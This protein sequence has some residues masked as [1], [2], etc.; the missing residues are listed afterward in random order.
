MQSE[1]S[2]LIEILGFSLLFLI[3]LIGLGR[4]SDKVRDFFWF[5]SGVN[6]PILK[7]CPNEYNRYSNIGATIFFT[8]LLAL[9]SMSYALNSVFQSLP[10]SICFGFIWS[11][12]IFT[13]DRTIVSS[14]Q[15]PAQ[16]TSY[17][18]FEFWRESIFAAIRIIVAIVI[19]LVIM[20]PL[21]I[22]IFEDRLA[23]EIKNMDD[24]QAKLDSVA[25]EGKYNVGSL[26][27]DIDLARS[28]K[29]EVLEKLG[30]EPPT[31]TY[32][33]LKKEYQQCN[34]ILDGIRSRNNPLISQNNSA[35]E[36]VRK[37]FTVLMDIN[38]V[39]RWKLNTE[40]ENKIK[41]LNW[42]NKKLQDEISAQ[43]SRCSVL[44]TEM[45][46]EKM[47]YQKTLN[48]E[49]V[50]IKDKIKKT[51]TEKDTAKVFAQFQFNKDKE[52]RKL[53]FS[54]TL[55][56]QIEAL[57]RLTRKDNTLNWVSWFI[58]LIFI[59][60]ETAPILAKLIAKRGDYDELI[61]SEKHKM[62]VRQQFEKSKIN[63]EINRS[64]EELQVIDEKTRKIV[65]A[66]ENA[67]VE[68]STLKIK[69]QLKKELLNN[70]IL[71][72]NIAQAQ[73]EIAEYI[74]QQWKEEELAKL[75]K[76]SNGQTKSQK[77]SNNTTN[78]NT[79]DDDLNIIGIT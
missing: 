59:A 45:R 19:S 64:L 53:S 47:N 27:K 49:L 70:E 8:A 73:R 52:T 20:K 18:E 1:L 61:D 68:L 13:L 33:N 9:V 11:L 57:G 7:Q 2:M 34:N 41:D 17:R 32:Q 24:D 25:I 67:F 54:S 5:C 15:K 30:K 79:I 26:S 78:S 36:Q 6:I 76:Q 44:S 56:T 29:D 43:S 16:E 4:I 3:I 51:E 28:D 40:G 55:V 60:I 71:L 75:G 48:E 22:K 77:Q 37:E 74:V 65:E 63:A 69:D 46:K 66:R 38:G 14:M 10:P 50:S 58:M 39:T 35:K 31:D 23:A 42:T 12:M 62:W 72:S 21:E